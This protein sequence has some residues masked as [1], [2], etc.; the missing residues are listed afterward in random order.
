MSRGLRAAAYAG[1]LSLVVIA[2]EIFLEEM[3]RQQPERQWLALLVIAIYVVSV[4]TTVLFYLGFCLLGRRFA[5]PA[6]TYSSSLIILLNLVWYT[7]QVATLWRTSPYYSVFGGTVLV[8]FGLSK[9]L[10]GYGIFMARD[11]LGRWATSIA[12]LEVVGGLFLLTVLW[13]LVG[14]V[15]S[16]VVTVLQIMLLL[17]LSRTIDETPSGAVLAA[18]SR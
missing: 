12:V 6:I 8:I 15:L 5:A 9:I 13:Y 14:F 17:R 11:R 16:L 1:I 2:P 18:K 4:A 7:F 3:F 10:F